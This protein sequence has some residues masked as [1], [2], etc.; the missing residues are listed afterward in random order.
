MLEQCQ[1]LRLKQRLVL[2]LGFGLGLGKDCYPYF[3][4]PLG[5]WQ[6]GWWLE[7]LELRLALQIGFSLGLGNMM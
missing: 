3:F 4:Q 2:Q 7:E 6:V 1:S 5:G